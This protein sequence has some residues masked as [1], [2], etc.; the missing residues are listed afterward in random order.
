M[1]ILHLTLFSPMDCSSPG[2]SVHG[3]PLR[4]EYWSGL[5]FPSPGD[6]LDPGMEPR[7]PV[8]TGGVFTIEPPGKPLPLLTNFYFPHSNIIVSLK[9]I[10]PT[11]F[12]TYLCTY[13]LFFLF[14]ILFLCRLWQN[15]KQSS[16]GYTVGLC[17]LFITYIHL[18]KI[19]QT[20]STPWFHFFS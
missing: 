17:W 14:K 7:S 12:Y 15:T 8:L 20:K 4:Q 18:K 11:G 16:L 6:L 1:L 2:S 19:G 9:L 10:C 13:T 5:P 3:F